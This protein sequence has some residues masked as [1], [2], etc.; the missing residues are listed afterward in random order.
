ME[1][2]NTVPAIVGYHCFSATVV[3]SCVSGPQKADV[4]QMR[5]N[6]DGVQ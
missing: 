4:G 3:H 5:R 2:G 6:G 1:I